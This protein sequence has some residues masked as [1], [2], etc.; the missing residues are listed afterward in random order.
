MDLQRLS[1]L[2]PSR[3]RL[4]RGRIE[5][6]PGLAV[7]AIL[8]AALPARADISVRASVSPQRAA[9]GQS[10]TLSVEINGAQNVVAPALSNLDGFDARYMGPST[11]ISIVN[12]RMNALVQH[13]YSLVPSRDGHF[14]LGPFTV[15]YDGK[16]YQTAPITVDIVKVSA[17]PGRGAPGQAGSAP[18]PQSLRLTLGV[19]K[20]EVYLHERL[21]I[22][23]T[24]YVGATRVAD[25]QYPT[26]AADGLSIEKFPE[27]I[28]QQEQLDGQ[29][30]Q[31]L[32]FQ[33]TITPLRAGNLALGPATLRL[34]VLNRRRSAGRNDP[35]FERFFGD[36]PFSTERRPL[37]LRSDPFT[38]NVLP[39][40]EE[41]KPV[42][43]SGAVGSFTLQV[44]ASPTE[45]TAGDPI[46]LRMALNGTGNLAES[47]PPALSSTDGF[48]I[49]EPQASKP[50]GGGAA[51]VSVART[52]EQVLIPNDATV[53]AIPPVRF[54]YFD[55]QAQRYETV[56]SQPVALVVRAPQNAPRSEIVVGGVPAPRGAPEEK[57]GRDIVYI[58][59]DPG[60]LQERARSWY[61]SVLFL[62]WQPL[63][64]LLFI[65]AVWYDRRRQRLS[66]D[67]RYAR[68]SRAGKEARR[69]LAA[70]QQALAHSDRGGFYDAVSRSMQEYLGAKLDLPPGGIDAGA[71][72][73]CGVPNDC[74]DAIERFFVTCEQVRFAPGAGDGDMRGTLSLAQD[75]VRR[76]ERARRLATP[77]PVTIEET[78][79]A[80]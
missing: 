71:T 17:P 55:P 64:L 31:V 68:F 34:S 9:V 22:E 66:G 4:L 40:P 14:T 43:F 58:K 12:G 49:Y 72:R 35:F 45:L 10:L 39:L 56:E 18:A 30:F 42:G 52:Y 51:S 13:R 26:L 32:H 70:A 59:D 61:G 8:L 16:Q 73:R 3:P 23:V 46:T 27:P 47:N 11:Q 80:S 41:G 53:R 74:A 25:V 60:H 57:L 48:R 63:P 15:E 7:A 78:R 36:D 1:P 75:I 5:G 76:L 50:E 38:L 37:D 33:T 69:G 54:S 21:P 77:P 24:L 29:T 62:L 79:A 44:A 65:G 6:L 67:L 28:Q 19:A 20:G 2:V